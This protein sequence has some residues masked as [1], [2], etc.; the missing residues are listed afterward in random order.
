MEEQIRTAEAQIAG[1][2][3]E[4]VD[5]MMKQQVGMTWAEAKAHDRGQVNL[6]LFVDIGLS[7]AFL[8]MWVWAKRNA[9]AASVT[10]LLIFITVIGINAVFDPK[11]LAQGII[12]K[13]FFIAAL[14]KAISVAQAER[15][16]SSIA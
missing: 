16:A 6:L 2:D 3:P 5:A 10:A 15:R 9:L 8:G 12:V 1:M 11:T 7:A 14:A 13:I 4:T